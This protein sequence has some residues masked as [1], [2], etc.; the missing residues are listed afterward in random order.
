MEIRAPDLS[1]RHAGSAAA[2][3]LNPARRRVRGLTVIVTVFI[4]L[5]SASLAASWMAVRVVDAT[6][7]YATGEGRYSKAQ[8]IAVLNLYR[9]AYSGRQSDYDAFLAATAVPRGDRKARLALE[10]RPVDAAAA[11]A[12]FRAGQND[13]ADIPALIM[14]FRSFSWW[15]P[16]AAA[17]AD[18][19]EGDRL[20]GE[21]IAEGAR[22]KEIA[23][24]GKLDSQ[25]R[26]RELDTIATIDDHLTNLENTFST[27][28]GEAARTA[29]MLVVVGLGVTMVLLWAVGMAF[30]T[31]LFH[32]Q[33]ALDGQLGL[34]E[35]RFRDYAEVASDW[36]WEI[37]AHHRIT[38]LS[39]QFFAVTHAPPERVLHRSF[40]EFVAAYSDAREHRANCASLDE[41]R[42]FRG[43]RLR[44][45]KKDR[46]V[47]YLSLSAKPHFDGAGKF[48]GYR[49]IGSDITASV[50]EAE[51]V[52]HM[53]LH[54]PLTDL[55][56]RLL[57]RQQLADALHRVARGEQCA[58]LCLDL[59][60]FKSV[61]DSLGH[62]VGDALIM[63]VAERLRRIVRPTD[64]VA[65]LGGDEFAIVQRSVDQPTDATAMATRIL[66][67]LSTPFDVAGHH[68]VISSSIGI[69]VAPGDGSDPDLLLKNA[70]IAL[71]QAKGEGRNRF[72]YFEPA[73][74]VRIQA[75]RQ[76]ELDLRNALAAG[77]FALFFQPFVNLA[78]ER[79][80]G[81]EALL[82]WRHPRRGMLLPADFIPVAEEIG[83]I[84]QLGEWVL[85]EACRHAISW[86]EPLKVAVNISGIHVKARNIVWAVTE[87]LQVSGLDPHR[88]ELEITESVMIYDFDVAVSELRQLKEL[89]VTIS[90]DDFGTGYSSLSCLRSFPFD[91]VKI[92]QSFVRELGNNSD[93]AAIVR[94]VIAM[95]E[96]LGMT[97]TAEGVETEEQLNL[98]R[99]EGCAE[100]Q[101]YLVS[102]PRPA[103]E[104]P[105]LISDFR[106]NGWRRTPQP[107]QSP[108]SALRRGPRKIA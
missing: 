81:F 34:S 49:G 107:R 3:P 55:P 63:A 17:V 37:D 35:Q 10:R 98:L 60:E 29:T 25:V 7:A 40:T 64:T 83:L 24:S 51:Q 85:H 22:L 41:R 96:S 43:L 76:L 104:I 75:R 108:R 27:H 106:R 48:L 94:A 103:R 23:D 73:M 78:Q 101:G 70:D 82:R 88:L 72:Y 67:E 15:Q 45:P 79:I 21:L 99:E 26:A 89:G 87:A 36:Y 95:C 38:Y 20:V 68:M 19:Q 105:T 65:R 58:V 84:I 39:E 50:K 12:G 8:K 16:F 18:W 53:A 31:R 42:P 100:I 30:A 47:V 9:F 6:R 28:M 92:D 54:D 4:L 1:P 59:D 33:M 90:M 91:K 44:Y 97:T 62:P 2:S 57:F 80:T 52:A 86:P 32:E 56:N 93:C 77:E 61:N 74:D 66:H 71:Y 11:A 69:A 46:S 102:E 5:L 14:L 13:P